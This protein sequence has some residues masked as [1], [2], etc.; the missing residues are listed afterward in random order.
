MERNYNAAFTPEG[1]NDA[2]GAV[3]RNIVVLMPS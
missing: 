3:A 2:A 1:P